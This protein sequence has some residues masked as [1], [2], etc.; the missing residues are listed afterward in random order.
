M[1]Q[2]FLIFSKVK[3]NSIETSDIFFLEVDDVDNDEGTLHEDALAAE[4]FI[5][6]LALD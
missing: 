4:F 6:L 1:H 3:A 2:F 5:S